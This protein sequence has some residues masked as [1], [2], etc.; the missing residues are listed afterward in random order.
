M[1]K[2]SAT[3]VG[4]AAQQS[5]QQHSETFGPKSLAL[6][7]STSQ[8]SLG[9]ATSKRRDLMTSPDSHFGNQSS[10]NTATG[11]N[12][13][14][15]ASRGSQNSRVPFGQTVSGMN[16]NMQSAANQALAGIG[17]ANAKRS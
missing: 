4:G 3:G 13:F 11:S 14:G 9:A 2:G 15:G 8:S 12:T 5:Q 17:G 16:F 6:K 1:Q 7:Q 10:M